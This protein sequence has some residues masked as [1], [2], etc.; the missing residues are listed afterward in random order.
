MNSIINIINPL[1]ILI[2]LTPLLGFILGIFIPD[3]RENL[4]SK[5]AICSTSFQFIITL[6][7]FIVWAI[8]GFRVMNMTEIT[9]YQNA[10]YHFFVDFLLS[11]LSFSFKLL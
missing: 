1:M 7:L 8:T 5:L 2:V 9:L 10:G 3:K 6:I 4:I 11:K